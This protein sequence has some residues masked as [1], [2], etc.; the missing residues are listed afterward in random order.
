MSKNYGTEI[1]I[2]FENAAKNSEVV[3]YHSFI[4]NYLQ[5]LGIPYPEN[6]EDFVTQDDEILKQIN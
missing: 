5:A 2:F 3:D 6:I 1:W 4:S